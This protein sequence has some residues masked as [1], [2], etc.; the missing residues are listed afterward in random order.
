MKRFFK[1]AVVLCSVIG[2][3]IVVD[4]LLN[5]ASARDNAY[6]IEFNNVDYARGVR[7]VQIKIGQVLYNG[8]APYRN[9]Y[10]NPINLMPGDSYTVVI[11]D[12]QPPICDVMWI[13]VLI[14][15]NMVG[16]GGVTNKQFRIRPCKS[17]YVFIRSDG[18]VTFQQ[19]Y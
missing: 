5:K 4:S 3:F 13:S 7:G 1:W 10:E 8:V 18:S 14:F 11:D 9:K 15:N 19:G 12:N 16:W 6:K 17:G 2:I